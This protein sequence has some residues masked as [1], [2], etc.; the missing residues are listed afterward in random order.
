MSAAYTAAAWAEA[1]WDYETR[2]LAAG[3]AD[4]P[5]DSGEYIASLVWTSTVRTLSD[6]DVTP[7]LMIRAEISEDGT[8]LRCVFNEAVTGSRYFGLF[9]Y[10]T[11]VTPQ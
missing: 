4:P 5:T 7:P 9:R 3:T 11:V 6:D 8:Q 10:T 2:E 1:I